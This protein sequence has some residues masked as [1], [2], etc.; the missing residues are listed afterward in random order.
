[1]A[2]PTKVRH[3]SALGA[4]MILSTFSTTSSNIMY[5]STYA[6]LGLVFGPVLG[7]TLQFLM[8][9]LALRVMRVAVACRCETFSD[10]GYALGGAPGRIFLGG[11]QLLNN[12]LF[13]P[14]ALV[15]SMGAL[16]ELLLAIFGCGIDD[17]DAGSGD[18]DTGDSTCEWLE[19]NVH[20]MLLTCVLAWPM[21]LFARDMAHLGG[22]AA[23]SIFLIAVQT[24]LI[25]VFAASSEASPAVNFT[26]AIPIG[27][28]AAGAD[29]WHVIVAAISVYLYSFCPLFV[30]VEVAA[31]MREPE[32]IRH[33]LILA[34]AFPC[35]CIYV[36][37][38]VAVAHYWGSEVPNPITLVLG[39]GVISAVANAMLLYSTL[40]DFVV[41]ATTVNEAARHVWA[42]AA[43]GPRVSIG[44]AAGRPAVAAAPLDRSLTLSSLPLWLLITLPA[45]MFALGLSLFVP[46]LDSLVGLLT[47]LCVP[48]AML[49]GPPGLLLINYVRRNRADVLQPIAPPTPLRGAAEFGH[50]PLLPVEAY[51][52]D[53]RQDRQAMITQEV[54]AAVRALRPRDA[55]LLLLGVVVGL[56]LLVAI[57]AET[58]WSIVTT[59]YAGEDYW[60][61]AIGA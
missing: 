51:G 20:L 23:L 30:A 59:D 34:Y 9:V 13:L 56:V 5:P 18:A 14:V 19:C 27:S 6:R 37:T 11:V 41:S 15:L 50:D 38:G 16:K 4:A 31:S 57:F 48:A 35:L 3:T 22:L 25:I 33:A 54:G 40:L 55:A 61:A 36:P 43:S 12:A 49:F 2:T 45:L 46:K 1:M 24:V 53:D 60:C 47:S 44:G 42:W 28:N 17:T 39:R 26:A 29:Q 7:V 58:I 10:L 32:R 8:C 52:A 21:L